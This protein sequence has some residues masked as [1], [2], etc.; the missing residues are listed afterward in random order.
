MTAAIDQSMDAERDPESVEDEE[1]TAREAEGPGRL[2][3]LAELG[4]QLPIGTVD[5]NTQTLLKSMEHRRWNLKVEKQVGA[6]KDKGRSITGVQYASAVLQS[7]YTRLGG[8]EIDPDAADKKSVTLRRAAI[9]Q[10][11]MADVLY[12]YVWLRR[13]TLGPKIELQYSCPGCGRPQMV[14]ADLDTL[15]VRVVD[16]IEECYWTYEL[17]YPIHARGQ[18]IKHLKMGPTRWHAI[19]KAAASGAADTGSVKAFVIWA[20]IMGVDELSGALLTE[21]ELDEMDKVDIETLSSEFD[22]RNVG[23]DM[24]VEIDCPSCHQESKHS[25]NWAADDFFAVSSRSKAGRS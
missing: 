7:L 18:E 8:I 9:G 23:P 12:A 5:Q 14:Y 6:L 10:L 3:R 20:A 17:K 11:W 13:Q 16:K 22:A 24:L 15:D 25:L 4:A 1:R 21:D 19:E 2:V